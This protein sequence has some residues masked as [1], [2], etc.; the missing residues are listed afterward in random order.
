MIEIRI[1]G[2]DAKS[3]VQDLQ[4]LAGLGEKLTIQLSPDKEVSAKRMKKE[5]APAEPAAPAK[6]TKEAVAPAGE[7]APTLDTIKQLVP[8]LMDKLGKPGLIEF[9]KQFAPAEKGSQ[10]PVDR[11]PEFVKKATEALG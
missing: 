2:D 7:A 8:K 5:T 10:V 9:F 4:A 11:Y 6:E 3:V 1:Q